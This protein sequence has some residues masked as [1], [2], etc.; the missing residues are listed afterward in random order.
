[1]YEHTGGKYKSH[2]NPLIHSGIII[3]GETTRR[4]VIHCYDTHMKMKLGWAH[5]WVFLLS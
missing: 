3:R 4:R 5:W 1:M 2:Q